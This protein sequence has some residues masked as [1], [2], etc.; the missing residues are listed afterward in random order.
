MLVK[1]LRSASISIAPTCTL[2]DAAE[3]VLLLPPEVKAEPA[4]QHAAECLKKRRRAR[5]SVD[6]V[7]AVGNDARA[8]R[9]YATATAIQM[10]GMERGGEALGSWRETARDGRSTSP[11]RPS[12]GTPA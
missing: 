8:P 4:W 1:F 9:R 6:V 5:E 12:S 2:K 7:C 10:G 11:N 3:Y